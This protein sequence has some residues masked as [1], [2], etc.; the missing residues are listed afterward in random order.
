MPRDE[1]LLVVLW[2]FDVLTPNGLTVPQ[3]SR[4]THG[5]RLGR[6]VETIV[7]DGSEMAAQI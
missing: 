6:Q 5:R 3:R 1:L 7:M 4:D 2:F